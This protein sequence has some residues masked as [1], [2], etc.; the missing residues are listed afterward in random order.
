MSRT[1]RAALVLAALAA[2]PAFAQAPPSVV[3]AMVV[4]SMGPPALAFGVLTALGTTG[5]TPPRNGFVINSIVFGSIAATYGAIFFGWDAGTPR[6]PIGWVAG[7]AVL[8]CV[9]VIATGLGVF[10]L[11]SM[12]RSGAW[13]N[14]PPPPPGGEPAGPPPPAPSDAPPPPPPLL[15]GLAPTADGHGLVLSLVGR[16]P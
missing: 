2:T 6:E 12:K 1:V 4:F 15:P 3:N 10:E 8:M 11:V 16:L 9:G 5:D 13:E 7:T 14:R